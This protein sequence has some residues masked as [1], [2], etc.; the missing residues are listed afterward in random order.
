MKSLMIT[1]A[2][3][4][5]SLMAKA[6]NSTDYYG[7]GKHVK[8]AK[9]KAKAANKFDNTTMGVSGHLVAFK[10]LP[11]MPKPTWAVITNAE[12]EFI[13]EGKINPEDN[14]VDI[15]K[16]N[17]GMYFVSIVYRNATKK[18]FVLNIGQ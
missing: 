14:A 16:L 5:L 8:M 17:K 2:L 12:G 18:A 4:T 15:R 1:S 6:Q 7:D 10:E 11:A 3:I 13:K 9:A